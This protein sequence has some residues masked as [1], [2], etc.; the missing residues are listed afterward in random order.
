MSIIYPLPTSEQL[1]RDDVEFHFIDWNADYGGMSA[2]ADA[3]E[4]GELTATVDRVYPLDQA[5]QAV[6]DYARRGKVG[7]LVVVM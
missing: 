4:R 2:V 7:H 1:A 5:V 3:A 6:T